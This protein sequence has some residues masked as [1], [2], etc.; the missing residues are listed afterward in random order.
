VKRLIVYFIIF[1]FFMKMMC[2][3]YKIILI[4]KYISKMIIEYFKAIKK[5]I[6][7]YYLYSLRKFALCESYLEQKYGISIF[8]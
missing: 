5:C 1:F 2:K 4:K 8:I 6:E 3:I 7:K